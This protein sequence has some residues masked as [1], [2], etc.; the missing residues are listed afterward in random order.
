MRSSYWTF[1]EACDETQTIRSVKDLVSATLRD[2]GVSGYAIA[3]HGRIE[4]LRS[5]GVLMH[6][7]PAE[8]IEWTLA[9]QLDCSPS[10]LFD[11]VEQKA[12]PV[13]WPPAHAR[14]DPIRKAQ[15]QWFDQLRQRVGQREGVSQALKSVV[16]GA[17]CSLTSAE[18]LDPD[19]VRLCMRIGNY[20]YQQILELQKPKLGEADQLTAREHELLYRA[21]IFGE[22]PADVASQVDVKIS[23]VRTLRQKA[24]VRLDAGSQ[25]QAAW[26]MVETGQLFRAGRKTRPRGR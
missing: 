26:R 6:N 5:L 24:S 15:R 4:D 16:V 10:P 18:R 2:F 1:I 17:S 21:T 3:T 22:R 8:A 14:R 19:R 23:T 9:H 13:Y 20:A 7:W 11:A 25:E 12:G